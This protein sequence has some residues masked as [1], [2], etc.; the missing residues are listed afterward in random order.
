VATKTKAITAKDR[1]ELDATV[2]RYISEGF[3]V[4][5]QTDTS[6]TMFKKKAFD[7]G[8]YFRGLLLCILPGIIYICRY[9]LE[10]SGVPPF[11]RF[12]GAV[13]V[14]LGRR[15]GHGNDDRRA[16]RA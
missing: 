15:G 5:R 9:A 14:P 11:P 4:A 3:T 2:T 12:S 7:L 8:R 6:V 16:E 1:T 10:A 13:S